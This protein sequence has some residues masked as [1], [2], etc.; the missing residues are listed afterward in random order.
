MMLPNPLVQSFMIGALALSLTFRIILSLYY[1]DGERILPLLRLAQG[2]EDTVRYYK[3]LDTVFAPLPF[4]YCWLEIVAATLFF[5]W[6]RFST[7]AGVLLVVVTAGRIRA[8]QEIGHNALHSA[9][10]PSKSFQWFLGNL[11]FQFPAIKRDMHS[12]F[13]VHVKDHHPY[14]DIPG[15]DPNLARVA[16]AG[17]V[18]GI[19]T[20]QFVLGLFYPVTPRDWQIRPSGISATRRGRMVLGGSS[21]SAS[22]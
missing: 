14:A 6:T 4:L 22:S 16:K 15:K 20:A 2:T 18:P 11:F 10:C 21:F 5:R 3:S 8:L 12:R 17:M 1:S 7:G 13:V 19:S 9:L